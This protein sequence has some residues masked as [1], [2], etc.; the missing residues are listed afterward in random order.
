MK[1]YSKALDNEGWSGHYN[2]DSLNSVV[3]SIISGNVSIWSEELV[4][5]TSDGDKVLEIGCGSG[6][7]SLWLAKHNRLVTALDYTES[8][9]ALLNAAADR[10]NNTPPVYL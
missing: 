10:L 1:N 6:T 2:L 7:S 4:K 3:N 9:V 8:A 5:I